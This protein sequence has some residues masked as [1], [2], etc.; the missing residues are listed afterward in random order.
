VSELGI[1]AQRQNINF[2]AIS[3][4]EQGTFDD[5]GVHFVLDHHALC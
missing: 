5:N 4:Q 2:S 1:V 3:W